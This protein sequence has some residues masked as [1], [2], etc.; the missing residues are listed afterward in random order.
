MSKV[1]CVPSAFPSTMGKNNK[2]IKNMKIKLGRLLLNKLFLFNN[3][4]FVQCFINI[5][6]KDNYNI[7]QKWEHNLIYLMVLCGVPVTVFAGFFCRLSV[8]FLLKYILDNVRRR[9]TP[10]MR[11][12]PDSHIPG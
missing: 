1:R 6:I 7:F 4:I 2:N 10:E 8:S 3:S 5:E 11:E 9:C 12:L